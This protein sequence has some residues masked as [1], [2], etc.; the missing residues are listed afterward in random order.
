MSGKRSERMSEFTKG[1]WTVHKN[2]RIVLAGGI[3]IYQSTGPGGAQSVQV[4]QRLNAELRANANLI[5]AAPELYAA[6]EIVLN[7][8]W[9]GPIGAEH[10]ARKQAAAALAKARGE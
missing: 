7:Q 10:H 5:A 2:G 4:Q 1:P 6:L 3:R 8:S 9:D